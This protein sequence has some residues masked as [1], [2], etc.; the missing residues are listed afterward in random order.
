MSTQLP[1]SMEHHPDILEMREQYERVVS[2]PRAQ[3]VEAL[4]M[5]AGLFLAVSPWVIGFSGTSGL[6]VNNLILGLAFTVLMA[7]YGSAYERTHARAWAATLIGA[8][9][10]MA[11]WL[12]SGPDAVRRTI[13][14]NVITGGLMF[15]LG[16]A[17]VGMAAG[18]TGR[19]MRRSG[20]GGTAAGG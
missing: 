18:L 13:L 5:L 8:W 14:T 6:T 20:S 4:A 17:A 2:T 7:G 10:I 15:C 12:V 16:M 9:T 11:P 19:G 1:M 3:A